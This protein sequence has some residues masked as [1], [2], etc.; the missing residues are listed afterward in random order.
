MTRVGPLRATLAR[1]DWPVASVPT[2]LMA[3]VLFID[4]V[5]LGW[6]G[7]AFAR[8][9]P[10]ARST[11]V[12]ALLVVLAL[13][14][15]EGARRAARLQ[16][17]LSTDLRLDMTSVWAVAA[18]VA[19]PPW[20][21]VVLLGAITVHTWF[22]HQ[23][24]AGRPLYRGWFAGSTEV[25]GC[26]TAG[27]VL[28]TW[29]H[30]WSALP[31]ALA[32]SVSVFVAIVIHTTINRSLITLA[33][34]GVGVRGSALLGSRHDN[35]IEFATLCLGGLV[36]LAVLYQPWLAV[37]VIAPMVTL[38][39]GALVRELEM[40][41]TTDAKTGL[42]NAVAWEHLAQ[43]ELSRARRERYAVGVLIIDI[44]RFKLVN[45]RYGHLVGD[46]VLRG[47]GRCIQDQVREYDSVGRFGGEE[48][49][50][51]L[52]D[53]SDADAL[54]IAER[55][56]SRVNSLRVSDLVDGANA[57]DD[58]ELAVSIGVACTPT[59]GD[60]LSDVLHAADGALYRA[61]AAGRNKVL[62]AERGSGQPFERSQR[63]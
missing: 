1:R 7:I 13:V 15:E 40:A 17:R 20:G 29:G 30:A 10:D 47:V 43:R 28:H 2:G 5:V 21:G 36:S 3:Y 12:L 62:L 50:A 24:P 60:E 9:R 23:R 52:P 38:Q 53:V 25:L 34:V 44:D 31:W 57:Y 14:F 54:V 32:G 33:L 41:A 48:F 46:A 58:D 26:L 11:W 8:A 59:D 42:L 56:R 16:L 39:R 22:R 51:V 18:A 6:A 49:V 35:L 61:K 19:L 4:A 55:V 45:D 63:F 27:L 37:L